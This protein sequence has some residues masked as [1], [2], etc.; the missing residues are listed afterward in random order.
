MKASS[1]PKRFLMWMGSHDGFGTRGDTQRCRPA[2]PARHSCC[3]AG[4]RDSRNPAHTSHG[5]RRSCGPSGTRARRNGVDPSFASAAASCS[6]DTEILH[7]PSHN[8]GTR[9]HRAKPTRRDGE[10]KRSRRTRRDPDGSSAPQFLNQIQ[11]LPGEWP[12][13]WM[14]SGC[15]PPCYLAGYAKTPVR[16]GHILYTWRMSDGARRHQLFHSRGLVLLLAGLGLEQVEL[17]RRREA[18]PARGHVPSAREEA[19][20]VLP[21]GLRV[22]RSLPSGG[23]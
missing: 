7:S 19:R 10:T 1:V 17:V 15:L 2:R 20:S 11:P 18:R 12:V 16:S 21:A 22:V 13:K 6:G 8:D 23:E 4:W 14:N 3:H 5:A 9:R